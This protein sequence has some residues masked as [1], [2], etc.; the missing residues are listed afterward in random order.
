V[1][2]PPNYTPSGREW[3]LGRRPNGQYV[4]IQ[5]E[6]GGVTWEVLMKN[7]HVVP[8]AHTHPNLPSRVLQK[9]G[10]TIQE[11]LQP[12]FSFDAMHVLPSVEDFGFAAKHGGGA[13]VV[14][15]PYSGVGGTAVGNAGVGHPITFRISDASTPGFL[16][17]EGM[18]H[19]ATLEMVVNGQVVWSG[20]VWARGAASVPVIQAAQPQ[21]IIPFTA[22][23]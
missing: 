23:P 16:R 3:G 20:R 4:I 19:T 1:T 15:T 6:T 10:V 2:P 8:L 12:R 22:A 7:E 13:H 21:G 9:P 18:V 11:L 14:E 5:G 17:G